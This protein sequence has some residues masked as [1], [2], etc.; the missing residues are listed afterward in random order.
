MDNQAQLYLII[1]LALV[2]FIIIVV[3]IMVLTK[4]R[5][6]T[7]TNRQLQQLQNENNKMMGN[8]SLQLSQTVRNDID[9]MTDLTMQQ[10]QMMI[11]HVDQTMTNSSASTSTAF[12]KTQEQ[13]IRIDQTQ[14]QISEVSR[15][16]QSLQQVLVDKKS[17]GTFGEIELYTLLQAAYGTDEHYWQKQYRLPNEVIADAVV[18]SPSPLN[19]IA[20]DSKFPME[21]YQR[22]IDEGQ[23]KAAIQQYQKAFCADVIRHIKD[24][25]GKYIVPGVTADFAYMF[26]PAEAVFAE[27]YGHYDNLISLSYQYHVFIVSPTTLM[28]YI[29]AIKAIGLGQ[30][31]NLQDVQLQIELGRLAKQFEL[32][33]TRWHKISAD[34]NKTANDISTLDVTSNK[35]SQQFERIANVQIEKQEE[36]SNDQ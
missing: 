8:F 19:M 14:Q 1:A 16:L 24:I 7:E 33:S 10:L 13:L 30:Q 18:F 36:S 32:F 11:Q 28:A 26:I 20:I 31:R 5:L 27:I 17:R 34:F 4:N 22:M 2:I 29:T 9:N 3:L 35:I 23:P 21:N 6:L 12:M 15:Q 25:A